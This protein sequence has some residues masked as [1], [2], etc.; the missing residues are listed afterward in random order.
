[1]P[2]QDNL[3]EKPADMRQQAEEKV[4]V[5]EALTPLN[6]ASLSAGE[7]QKAF[8]ELQVH[9]IELE[10]QNEELR[11]AQLERNVGR[12]RYFNL[13]ELAPVGYCTFSAS[14]LIDKINLTAA[15]L[16]GKPRSNILKQAFSRFI[17]KE[18]QPI[19]YSH[20]KKLLET[21]TSQ[22]CELR[23][24]KEDGTLWWARLE[25]ALAQDE[26]GSSTCS[27]TIS[28]ITARKLAEEQ[29][30]LRQR[31]NQ[32]FITLAEFTGRKDIDL[33]QL[34]QEFVNKLPASWQYP[35]ITYARLVIGDRQFHTE[36]YRDSPWKQFA[37]VLLKGSVMGSLEVGYLE[38]RPDQGDG[39]FFKETR[40]LLNRLAE[41]LGL[42][43]DRKQSEESLRQSEERF[44][45]MFE[46]N[47]AIM[48]L[49]DPENARIMDANQAAAE[50]YGY[51]R[52]KLRSLKITDINTLPQAQTTLEIQ[53][54]LKKE[55][56]LFYFQHRLASGEIRD[57]EIYVSSISIQN[58]PIL[59]SI[60]HDVTPRKR[61]EKLLMNRANELQAFYSLS[62]IASKEGLTLDNLF[63]EF[64]SV[65][66]ASWQY[67]EIAC[68]R[69]VM[70]DK[71]FRTEN[72]RDSAWKQSAPIKLLGAVAGS[73]EVAYLEERP[74]EAEG[75]FIAEERYLL[76]A[77]AE[78]LG[79]IAERKKVEEELKQTT[80]KLTRSNA[81]LTEFAYIASHDL[82][83]PLR[84]VSSYLQ[85]IERRYRDKLDNDGIEF[86]TFAVDGANRMQSM[87]NDL[88]TFSRVGTQG[89]PFAPTDCENVLKQTL[90]NLQMLIRESQAVVTHDPLPTLMADN[91]QM[92]QLF[93]NLISNAVKFRKAEPPQVHISA[94]LK[95]DD[96]EFSVRDN[97]IGIESQYYERIF[98]IFQRLH[99]KGKYPGNGIG[100]AVCKK[101]VERHGG[102]IRVESQSDQGS[103]FYF[104]IPVKNG[105][106]R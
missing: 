10:M 58:R 77:L 12:E 93:Q 60:V 87:I 82:Q 41:R 11:R 90:S 83:E 28:D 103:T 86:M 43:I 34:L 42:V 59:F 29:E 39:P 31:E 76:N 68:A 18:D 35:E 15:S 91:T 37:P 32:A 3:P 56:H 55:R 84:M 24:L 52:E 23:M 88:L 45:T 65:L 96:W 17:V 72:Y 79:K 98:V 63:Q 54:V 1:M 92:V 9:Q 101:V 89:K 95:G 48:L 33:D 22:E 21:G 4:R 57:V 69:L 8:H 25:A 26:E 105:G 94:R 85:L 71:E 19:Y 13:F 67:P 62:E 78:R 66:S 30:K 99:G 74:T 64:V 102:K 53:N 6:T 80:E 106:G 40:F 20:R 44:R 97:G 50:F 47:K 2:N 70:G 49:I 104:T 38:E 46:G 51:S 7:I 36:N 75:P 5:R 73:L 100:L 16:L 27:I 14:G 61:A 81:D